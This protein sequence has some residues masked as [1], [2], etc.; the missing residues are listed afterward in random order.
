MRLGGGAGVESWGVSLD[1]GGAGL[2]HPLGQQHDRA[3]GAR[4]GSSRGRGL[5]W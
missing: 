4:S 3:G 1:V 5:A 2:L